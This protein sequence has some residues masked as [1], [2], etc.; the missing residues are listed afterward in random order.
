MRSPLDRELFVLAAASRSDSAYLW[1]HHHS[2]ALDAGLSEEEI[3]RVPG[4]P[5]T[6]GGPPPMPSCPCGRRAPRQPHARPPTWDALAQRYNEH[7]LIE[8][9]TL[10]GFY[11]AMGYTLN[12]WGTELESSAEDGH[13]TPVFENTPH[14]TPQGTE[15]PTLTTPRIPPVPLEER[16]GDVAE[17]LSMAGPF[18]GLN[19]LSATMV[20]HPRLYKRWLPF[21][22]SML[23]A[24]L[25]PRDREL[26]ILRTAYRCEC[27]Y[28]VSQHEALASGVGLSSAD[29]ERI[30]QGDHAGLTP[31]DAALVQA[32]DELI[33]EHRISEPPPGRRWPQRWTKASSSRYR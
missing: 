33:D 15:L 8:A 31:H 29:V 32:V 12:S 1:T 14:G 4:A 20:R 18:G 23:Y 10:I 22:T 26:L 17:L 30:R 7:Q 6:G 24:H 19:I 21:G 5:R 25:P 13:S 11:F 27:T 28:E 16:V 2:L 3:A 9:L